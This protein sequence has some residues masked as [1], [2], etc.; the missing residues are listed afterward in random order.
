MEPPPRL[1]VDDFED[2]DAVPSNPRF[3]SWGCETY[4][5]TPHV[6]CVSSSPGFRSEV[7]ETVRFE[8]Q[9]PADAKTDHP[10]V[11]L[12]APLRLGTLDLGAYTS[13]MFSAKLEVDSPVPP[14]GSRL[15]VRLRCDGVGEGSFVETSVLVGLEWSSP[16]IALEAF[17]RPGYVVDFDRLACVASVEALEFDIHPDLFDGESM[18]GTLT[19]DEISLE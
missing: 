5:G 9:D 2:G 13:L 16:A 12:Q 7:A 4:P 1:D 15:Y 10:G 14:N 17:V 8:I 11:L 6:S 3:A 18:A 19:I